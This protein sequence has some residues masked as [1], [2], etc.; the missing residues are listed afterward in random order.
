MVW[1]PAR[2]SPNKRALARKKPV[3]EKLIPKKTVWSRKTNGYFQRIVVH[4][5]AKSQGGHIPRWNG[6]SGKSRIWEPRERLGCD[7]NEG[8]LATMQTWESRFSK[9]SRV[10]QGQ[11]R[12]R[13]FNFVLAERFKRVKHNPH[14]ALEDAWGHQ[15]HNHLR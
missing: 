3:G 2:S 8:S 7:V 4:D 11:W 14:V 15:F 13:V 1:H 9:N 5:P 10:L 12:G 6:S